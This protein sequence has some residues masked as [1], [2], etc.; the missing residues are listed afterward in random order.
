MLT[1]FTIV[2]NG[3]PFISKKLDIFLKL[4]IPWQWK[5]VE[6]VAAAKNCT[7]WCNEISNKWHNNFVSIDGTH[8]YLKN[9][10]NYNVH[11]QYQNKPWNGKIE[12]IQKALEDVNSGVVMEQDC[13]EFWS[14][15][16]IEGAYNLLKDEAVG[17]I[18]QF[19]CN[20]FIGNKIVTSKEGFGSYAYEWDRVWVWGDGV[21]FISHEPPKINQEAKRISREFTKKIG[22]IFDHY[23]YSDHSQCAFKEEFYRYDGLLKSWEMLQKTK[24]PVFLNQYFSFIKDKTIV[25]DVK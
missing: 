24:G 10:K 1:I 5:I 8:E 18:A 21:K 25:D 7:S 14:C 16:Q 6:G 17:T 9:I 19:Y 11:V 23:A 20:Y 3:Q 4:K 15:E 12:M 13:D 2:L 22:L